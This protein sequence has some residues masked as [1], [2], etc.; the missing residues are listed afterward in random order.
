MCVLASCSSANTSTQ[1]QQEES[2][3]ELNVIDAMF[4]EMMLP[5]HEQ[6][7]RMTWVMTTCTK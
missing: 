5:H 7:G 1:D 6:D 2:T 4:V 3:D